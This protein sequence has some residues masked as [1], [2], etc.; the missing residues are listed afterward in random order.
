M[1]FIRTFFRSWHFT[2]WWFGDVRRIFKH[3]QPDLCHLMD[4]GSI[5]PYCL[6]PQPNQAN[7][8][9]TRSVSNS[10]QVWSD[11][12][13]TVA[14]DGPTEGLRVVWVQAW[15]C[16]SE[17]MWKMSVAD[18]DC[19]WQTHIVCDRHSMSVIDTDCLLL[20]DVCGK[21]LHLGVL[22][23]VDENLNLRAFT[24]NFK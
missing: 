15:Q 11:D 8:L 5:F 22:S 4:I 20:T 9:R 10:W 21:I 19:L 1:W 12:C 6:V 7:F 14:E 3:D 23:Q 2:T 16:Y 13:V 17:V 24:D 18:T